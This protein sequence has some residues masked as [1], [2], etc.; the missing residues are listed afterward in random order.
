MRAQHDQLQEEYAQQEQQGGLSLLG[1]DP[2]KDKAAYDIQQNYIARTKDAADQLATKGFIDSGRRRGLMEIKSLYTNQVVPLQNQ[3]KIRQERAEELRKIQLQDP[4]FRATINPNDISLTEGLKSPT[5]F[6]YDGVSG[7]QLYSTAAKKLEQL[8][9]TINQD[10]PELKKMP[11]LSFQYFTAIQSGA[12]PDQAANAMKR[13]GY[14]PAVV[15]K[16]TNMIHGTIDSTMREFGVYDKFKGND[17]AINELWDSTSQAAYKAIG[18]K[19]FGQVHDSW[20]E[21]NARKAQE[22]QQQQPQLPKLGVNY[23]PDITDK[24]EYNR[25]TEISNGA[26]GLVSK[27]KIAGASPTGGIQYSY[28]DKSSTESINKSKNELMSI[29]KKNGMLN[30]FK[31]SS[32][33]KM[34]KNDYENAVDLVINAEQE[35]LKAA[36]PTYTLATGDSNIS[37][38]ISQAIKSGAVTLPKSGSSELNSKKFMELEKTYGTPVITLSATGSGVDINFGDDNTF[39]ADGSIFQN[40]EVSDAVNRA[41]KFNKEMRSYILNPEKLKNLPK[42]DGN[43]ILDLTPYGG[44]VT[45]I[46]P[47]ILSTKELYNYISGVS[48]QLTQNMLINTF[49]N[50]ASQNTGLT[51]K[52]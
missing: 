28:D 45:I 38:S 7:N 2:V 21:G 14:D 30:L 9:K 10:V 43:Y 48:Q 23:A 1:I 25:L 24:D 41:Q 31:P 12:T 29:A 5:A 35:R 26:K 52:N 40:K 50:I 33:G 19:Q 36:T 13:E 16:M 6:N 22:Q 37:K 17:K 42:N 39:K 34:S 11:K 51:I 15:D 32:T 3:L 8:S 4:T 47:S 27:S 44:S 46:P 49:G 18:T 20:G